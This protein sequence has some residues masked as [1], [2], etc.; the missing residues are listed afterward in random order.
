MTIVTTRT[1]TD[2]DT[3]KSCIDRYGGASFLD[4]D[5]TVELAELSL[6]PSETSRT[7]ASDAEVCKR[8][9]QHGYSLDSEVEGQWLK[10]D[11]ACNFTKGL[12]NLTSH[13][14]SLVQ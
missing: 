6:K 2:C 8:K 10:A 7:K 3:K 11:Q 13:L 5:V 1:K 9:V 12:V 4:I 14:T